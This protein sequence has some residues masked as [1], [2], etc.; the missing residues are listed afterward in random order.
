[1]KRKF[2]AEFTVHGDNKWYTN[3]QRFDTEDEAVGAAHARWQ[4]WSMADKYRVVP[5]DHPERE[6][7]VP[8]SEHPQ[9]R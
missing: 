4:V 2:R 1:M 7:Y 5:E 8:G 3:L 9:S 6:T